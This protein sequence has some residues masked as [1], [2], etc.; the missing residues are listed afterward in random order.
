MILL[1]DQ[2]DPI[3]LICVL[4][5]HLQSS[6]INT[7]VQLDSRQSNKTNTDPIGHSIALINALEGGEFRTPLMFFEN[8]SRRNQSIYVTFS[9]PD[10]N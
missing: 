10:Q 4:L 8:I 1:E 2:A 7:E 6:W 5:D 3:G 9:V